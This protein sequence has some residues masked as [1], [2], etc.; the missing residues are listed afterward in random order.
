[1]LPSRRDVV[2][3]GIGLGCGS[4]AGCSGVLSGTDETATATPAETEEQQDNGAFNGASALQWLPAPERVTPYTN[5][6]AVTVRPAEIFDDDHRIR[7]NVLTL[8]NRLVNRHTP[9]DVDTRALD[10][11][12]SGPAASVGTGTYHRE[13]VAARL[14][15]SGYEQRGQ[16]D[17]FTVYGG[18]EL[19]F[20][21]GDGVFIVGRQTPSADGP[22]VIE[23][24]I[25][26][27]READGYATQTGV[28]TVADQLSDAAF[29]LLV[30]VDGAATR[31]PE[32][33]LFPA[34]Q[35]WGRGVTPD[36][37]RTTYRHV[38]AFDGEV[39]RD[40][41]EQW[42]DGSPSFGEGYA[43]VSETGPTLDLR[44][45]SLAAGARDTFGETGIER[46]NGTVETVSIRAIRY[47]FLPLLNGDLT[48]QVG[49]PVT[50]EVASDDALHGFTI[51]GTAIDRML[52][53][54]ETTSV[55]VSFDRPGTRTV[56]CTR[57]CGVG[58]DAMQAEFDVV[59]PDAP[60][61]QSYLEDANNY[62]YTIADRRN[63]E[64]VTIDVGAG[65]GLSF[66]PAAVRIS[67]G[68]TVSW[69][70][71][72]NGG[73][74]NIVAENERFNSGS[75]QQSGSFDVTFDTEGVYRYYCVPHKGSGMK[76]AIQVA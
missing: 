24:A 42:A 61:Y 5:P 11:V 53:P 23:E 15:E 44:L 62:D 38:R 17:G 30:P 31:D 51:S 40:G 66:D 52:V 55:T 76:G 47:A 70:W 7:D 69:E 8:V 54:G 20:G 22:T 4:L 16:Q 67:P 74:H 26:A 9:T 73:A 2:R 28:G 56:R 13:T 27:G 6:P 60:P 64:T 59:D 33:G 37:E 18:T 35:S 1:M 41:I 12:A 43:T 72:G 34:E 75:P 19:A 71:T 45:S 49:Q 29:R 57:Y 10:A 46:D 58:H 68:T 36:G 32:R 3:A 48:V 63:A 21:L 25:Q 14:E 50:F 65:N 39:P